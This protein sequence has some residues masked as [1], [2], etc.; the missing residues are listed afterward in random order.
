MG[1]SCEGTLSLSIEI[2]IGP[3]GSIKGV[4]WKAIDHERPRILGM[5][6]ADEPAKPDTSN[7]VCFIAFDR[8]SLREHLDL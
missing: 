2:G 4:G 5:K 6:D 8:A 7:G 3:L 1:A